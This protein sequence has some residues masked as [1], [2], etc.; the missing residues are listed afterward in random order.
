MT[1]SYLEDHGSD[2]FITGRL[3]QT[4]IVIK[5]STD[6]E[7]EIGQNIGIGINRKKASYFNS[8]SGMR[9]DDVIWD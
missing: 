6:I 2:K 5:D 1:I 4:P 8:E 7:Y 9:V 3:N